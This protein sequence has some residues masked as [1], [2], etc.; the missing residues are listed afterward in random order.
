MKKAMIAVFAITTVAV[1]AQAQGTV[2]DVNGFGREYAQAQ[3]KPAKAATAAAKPQAEATP[4]VNDVTRVSIQSFGLA[5]DFNEF[6]QL[7]VQNTQK[8]VAKVQRE[9]EKQN[10]ARLRAEQAKQEAAQAQQ[11]AVPAPTAQAQQEVAM[12]GV[13][14]YYYGPEGKILALSD[15]M[16]GTPT[17]NEASA[18]SAQAEQTSKKTKAAPKILKG[19]RWGYI[20]FGPLPNESEEDYMFRMQQI[21]LSSK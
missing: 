20:G 14:Y 17:D 15:Q 9:I 6:G 2:R 18:K 12:S 13:P 3:V 19:S 8:A 11:A 7:Y 5:G 16:A 4:V 10:I 21:A 1:A